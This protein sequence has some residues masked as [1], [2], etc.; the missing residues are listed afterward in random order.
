M[1]LCRDA[2]GAIGFEI[3]VGGGQG[4]TPVVAKKVR[5]Y[6]EKRHLLSYLEAILRVYNQLGRRDNIYKARIKI[7]VNEIGVERFTEL[8]EA[9]WR[10]IRDGGLALPKAEIERIKSYFAPPPYDALDATS[11][12]F[13]EKRLTDPGLSRVGSAPTSPRTNSRAMPSSRFH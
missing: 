6:L 9:E 13:E 11:R 10:E 2:D 4:R 1:A 7:L 3:Y 5:G 12:A 8:V